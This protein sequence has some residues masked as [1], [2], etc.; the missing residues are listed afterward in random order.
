MEKL[1]ENMDNQSHDK[2]ENMDHAYIQYMFS[3]EDI[4]RRISRG[5]F[6]RECG[7]TG[8]IPVYEYCDVYNHKVFSLKQCSCRSVS[9]VRQTIRK[10][11][12]ENEIE[13]KTFETYSTNTEWRKTVKK[14]AIDYLKE[15]AQGKKYWFYIGGQTGSGKTH[16]CTAIANRFLKK[17][18]NLRYMSWVQDIRAIKFNFSDTS[19]LEDYKKCEVLY[20]DDLFKGSA[21][22]SEYDKSIA[23]E[24]FNYRESNK[25]ITIVSSE[26]TDS[27]LETV[28]GAIYGRIKSNATNRFM[29][30]VE[31]SEGKNYRINEQLR[32]K[33]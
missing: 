14:T 1:T 11:G 5:C 2:Y 30:S 13:T 10:S 15:I 28:D 19:R 4:E 20:I 31:V 8:W 29:V 17:N 27:E 26:L 32:T 21:V 24:I 3:C 16:I 25:L 18:Y 22:P 33:E 9:V 12:L 7:D 6:C 23:F